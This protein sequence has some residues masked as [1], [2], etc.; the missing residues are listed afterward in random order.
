MKAPPMK[1]K[2]PQSAKLARTGTLEASARGF[3][4]RLRLG[5]GKK[6]KR[7]PIEAKSEAQART[8]LAGLQAEEDAKGTVLAAVVAGERVTAREQ[9]KQVDGESADAWHARFLA[10]RAERYPRDTIE[11]ERRWRKWIS[12]HLGSTPMANV[13]KDQV[14]LVRDGLDEAR[15][16]GKLQPGSAANVWTVLTTA[17]RASVNSKTR[18]LRAR[19]MSPCT[20]VIPPDRGNNRR[21]HWLYPSEFVAL[22]ECATVPLEWRLTYAVGL[23]SY[24]RP[25]ELAELRFKDIDWELRELRITRAWESRISKIGDT[26]SHAGVRPVPIHEHLYALLLELREGREPEDLVCPCLRAVNYN[27][28]ARNIQKHLK[29]AGVTRGIFD[30][31]RTHVPINF[32][33]LRDAGITWNAIAGVDPLKLQR[34]AGHEDSKTTLGYIKEA[35]DRSQLTGAVF[36]ALTSLLRNAPPGPGPQ[37]PSEASS[38]AVADQNTTPGSSAPATKPDRFQPPWASPWTRFSEKPTFSSGICAGWTG[39]E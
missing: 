24:L 25:G 19:A 7:F 21:K 35:E 20:D 1:S 34:R 4:G 23:Y 2:L 15:R 39:L 10:S 30:N 12:P 22:I 5:N 8:I 32:R 31:T 9:C 36:P 6:S 38:P 29:A 33:S 18:N 28:P 17:F 37:R 13:T 14:E 26:K 3:T 27:Q 16:L 11:A